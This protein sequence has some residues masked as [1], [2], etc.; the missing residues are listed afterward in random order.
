[1]IPE[2]KNRV[3]RTGIDLAGNSSD[4][5]WRISVWIVL[6]LLLL[7]A[8]PDLTSPPITPTGLRQ[9]QTYSQTVNFVGSGFSFSGL[10]LDIDGPTPLHVVHELPVYQSIVGSLFLLFG[11]SFFAGK[12]LS[13]IATLIGVWCAMQLVRKRLG[14]DVT[15]RA[16]L[17]FVSCP[18]GLLLISSFQPDALALTIGAISGLALARWREEATRIRWCLFVSCIS[19]SALTKFTVLVPFLPLFLLLVFRRREGWRFLTVFEWLAAIALFVI[20]FVS[21][22]LYRGTL[23]DPRFLVDERAMFILGDLRRF[24]HAV[25]YVKPAL[26]VGVMV[27]C[28]AGVPLVILGMRKLDAVGWALVCG[29]PFNYVLIPT[30]ADQTYYAWPLM[31]A[32]AYLAARGTLCLENMVKPAYKRA[33]LSTIAVLWIAGFSIAAP[34]TI[35]NDYVSLEAALAA[36]RTSARE[37]LLFV[38]NMH[39]RGVAIGGFNPTIITLAER[40]G[41]NVKFDSAAPAV[42]RRQIEQKR[43]AGARWLIATWYS[44]DLEPWFSPFLPASFGRQP[45]FNGSLVDGLSI[46]QQLAE[47]YP[48][49]AEGKNYAILQLH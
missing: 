17:F 39:D 23:M 21:W 10:Y 13:L 49:I 8:L 12:L 40:K 16:G 24:L 33:V 29:I 2:D 44:P 36:K 22:N 41:W 6:G 19:L 18:V 43:K 32:L 38:I 25:F 5:A 34:Y 9:V 30:V 4:H 28:G 42:L 3:P 45:K 20:P 46:T 35:R 27:L 7:V 26:I 11:K 48:K 15:F 31:P 14:D 47:F 1:M 37:D